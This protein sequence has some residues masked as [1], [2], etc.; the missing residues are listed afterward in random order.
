[1]AQ[2]LVK[3]MEFSGTIDWIFSINVRLCDVMSVIGIGWYFVLVGAGLVG[4][5][6]PA[7]VVN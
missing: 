7:S 4:T 6:I 5:L 3:S 1:M 2:F